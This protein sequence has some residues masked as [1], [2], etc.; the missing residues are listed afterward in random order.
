MNPSDTIFALS[1]GAGVAGIAVLRV[2]GPEAIAVAYQLA[3]PLGNDRQ[4]VFRRLRDPR[5][6]ELIDAGL[7]LLFQGPRSFTGEDVVEFHVHGSLAVQ[8]AM[9]EALTAL[10]LRGAEPGEFTRRAVRNGRMDLI[11]A[12]GLADLVRAKTERQRKQALRHS[13]GAVSEVLEDWRG[14]LTAILARVEAAVDFVDEPGVAEQALR[15]VAEPIRRLKGRMQ[16]ALAE[17][18][19]GAA[20]RDGIRVVIAGPP[21]VGKSSLLNALARRDAAIVS[22][23]PGTTRDVIEVSFELA[24]IPVLMSDTAGLRGDTGDE[25]ERTGMARTRRELD[26][27]DIVLWVNAPDVMVQPPPATDVRVLAVKNK[28]DLGC[29]AFEGVDISVKTGT[30]LD[31]LMATLG[32]E[33][34]ALSS[35]GENAILV[36]IRHEDSIRNCIESLNQALEADLQHLEIFAEHL[37]AACRSIG[38]LTGVINI[39][40][41]LDSIFREFCIGK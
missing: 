34:S 32:R 24:G 13:L 23:L 35:G 8:R 31:D 6:D 14:N 37:R 27:A 36:R 15:A 28:S 18:H 21:N 26:Q 40:D 4:A 39:E 10:G 22:P 38:T 5:T 33:V 16:T 3:G 9:T 11:E 29:S 25:L 1:S 17:M 2:S 41:V 20:V 12:E 7:V 19:R 30:G